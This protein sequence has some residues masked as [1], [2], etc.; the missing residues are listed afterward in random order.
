MII[1]TSSNWFF[2]VCDI[3]NLV[4]RNQVRVLD[5]E[6]EESVGDSDVLVM[7]TDGL[8]DVVSNAAVAE[9]VKAG[10]KLYEDADETRRR[11]RHISIAQVSRVFCRAPV[12][13]WH[14]FPVS[15]S[16]LGEQLP[17]HT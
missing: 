15:G 8:W 13:G 7:A 12:L 2:Y 9:V 11:Y 1:L 17:P 10:L 6:R 3:L 4:S 5:V 14:V 16:N